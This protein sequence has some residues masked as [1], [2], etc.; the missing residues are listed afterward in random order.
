MSPTT[1]PDT[2]PTLEDNTRV[3]AFPTAVRLYV[4]VQCRDMRPDCW[5]ALVVPG[6]DGTPLVN[7]PATAVYHPHMAMGVEV[8]WPAGF[9][10]V[11]T[12]KYWQGPYP[13]P[14]T[15]S[16]R[17]FLMEVR[18][19]EARQATPGN[20]PG[21]APTEAQVADHLLPGL[22]FGPAAD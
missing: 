7:L 21:A 10:T 13:P 6:P 19:G 22:R 11:M 4:G 5:V 15:A 17:P 8:D 1:A 16:A 14:A 12:L 3:A 20:A 18:Q 9:A 2:K